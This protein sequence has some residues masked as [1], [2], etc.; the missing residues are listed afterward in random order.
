[1]TDL[2]RIETMLIKQGRLLAALTEFVLF[3]SAVLK[4]GKLASEHQSFRE[5][6][7]ALRE[8]KGYDYE[9]MYKR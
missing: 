5:L 1:M 4:H 2:D 9:P 3:E 6:E 7:Q 8:L